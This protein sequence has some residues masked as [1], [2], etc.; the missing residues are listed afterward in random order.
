[1][2]PEQLLG[3]P[4]D[5]RVDIFAAALVLWESLAGRKPFD[6]ESSGRVMFQLVE[7]PAPL[8][9]TIMP[10][11]PASLAAVVAKAASLD[12]AQRFAT[13]LE[14]ARALEQGSQPLP[15]SVIGDWVRE[16]VGGTL[17]RRE[18]SLREM[19]AWSAGHSDLEEETSPGEKS[20]SVPI[21]T[22]SGAADTEETL[23]EISA[24]GLLDTGPRKI[25]RPS[26]KKRRGVF[27][28]AGVAVALCAGALF[29]AGRSSAVHAGASVEAP[30]RPEVSAPAP[31][32]P[33]ASSTPQAA[34]VLPAPPATQ[35]ATPAVGGKAPRP[36]RVFTKHAPPSPSAV[37]RPEDLFSRE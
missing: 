5:R 36:R 35:E 30:A 1:M 4:F 25:P 16:V 15:P 11:L 37:R 12:P 2:S 32:S 19:E 26:S 10:H 20:L 9:T 18:A 17:A 8:L 33:P 23:S 14:F 27:V 21:L 31:A 22:P 34:E 13:A 29:A 6:G 24:A 3:K 28:G 7:Q